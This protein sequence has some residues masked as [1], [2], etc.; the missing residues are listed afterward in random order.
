MKTLI[1]IL[2]ILSSIPSLLLQAQPLSNSTALRP[3]EILKQRLVGFAVAAHQGQVFGKGWMN[4]IASFEQAYR[5]GADIIEFD[6]RLTKDQIPI[7]YHD[8]DLST[9]TECSGKVSDYTAQEIQENCHF[10]YS[11]GGLR[12][13]NHPPLL[14]EVLTWSHGKM[15]LDGEFKDAAVIEPT[16]KLVQGY[17]AHSW[18]YFQ[19]KASP[20]NYHLARHLDPEVVLLYNI[21]NF[22]DLQWV[23][24]LN[25][26]ALLIIELHEETRNKEWLSL[27]HQQGK[28][29]SENAWHFN[30]HYEFFGA[31]CDEVFKYGIDIA[32]SNRPK[33]CVRQKRHFRN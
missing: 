11:N 3:Y 33:D 17:N 13:N 31:S 18:V 9:W 7:I 29:A 24:G 6:L 21:R 23:L 25:D 4:S 26:P 12:E 1:G 2:F 28:L 32:V 19:T 10:S 8:E 20:E 30:S 14:S 22:E 15:I 5:D 16:V 27:I